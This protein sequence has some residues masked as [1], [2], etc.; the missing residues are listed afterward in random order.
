[1][2]VI[3]NCIHVLVKNSNHNSNRVDTESNDRFEQFESF[4]RVSQCA[5]VTH[6]EDEPRL[7]NKENKSRPLCAPRYK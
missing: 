7:V 4:A 3:I 5:R 6:T 2:C 1:M